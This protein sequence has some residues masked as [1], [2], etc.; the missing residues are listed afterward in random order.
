MGDERPVCIKPRT[1]QGGRDEGGRRGRETH[2]RD[3][4]R[5]TSGQARVSNVDDCCVQRNEARKGSIITILSSDPL[6]AAAAAAGEKVK[7]V[8]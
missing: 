1:S 3:T 7:F 5:G 2:V 4:Y 6:T 8:H